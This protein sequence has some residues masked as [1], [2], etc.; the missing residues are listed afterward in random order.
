MSW[1]NLDKKRA[2]SVHYSVLRVRPDAD[3][4]AALR[5]MFPEGK[6]DDLNFVLFS[7]SGVHGTYCLIEAVEQRMTGLDPE[8]PSD[9]TFVVVHPRLVAMRY[10][11]CKPAN[12]DDIDFLK[13][14]R[15]SSH[16]VVASIGVEFNPKGL[17]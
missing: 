8:G 2:D 15:A 9:V 5:E 7:T 11:V 6:A 13:R 3:E 12:Q 10:G 4:M 17:S 1:E 16:E 14:L